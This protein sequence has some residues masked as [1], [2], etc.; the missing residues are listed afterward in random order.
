MKILFMQ[1]S[2]LKGKLG[3]I[4][5]ISDDIIGYSQALSTCCLS[6]H[7]GFYLISR[8]AISRHDAFDLQA[9]RTVDHN[10]PVT[11]LAIST[12]L[13]QQRHGENDVG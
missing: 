7:D 1:A 8:N 9:F 11:A 3:Q 2:Y 5:I 6:R 12:G 10:N 13:H 4:S